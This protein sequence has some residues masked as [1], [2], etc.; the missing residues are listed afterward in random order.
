MELERGLTQKTK[1]NTVL[2]HGKDWD[3]SQE[4]GHGNYG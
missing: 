3:N 2:R 1:K 4:R